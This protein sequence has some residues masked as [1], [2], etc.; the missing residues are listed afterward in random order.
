MSRHV[1]YTELGGFTDR[2]IEVACFDPIE[3]YASISFIVSNIHVSRQTG[4]GE[5]E[6][7]EN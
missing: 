6:Y 2:Q 7:L 1:V 5:T 4:P 3:T